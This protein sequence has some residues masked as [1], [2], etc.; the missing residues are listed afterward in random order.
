[1]TTCVSREVMGNLEKGKQFARD[2]LKVKTDKKAYM[3]KECGQ[4]A[5]EAAD[6]LCRRGK[7]TFFPQDIKIHQINTTCEVCGDRS[8]EAYI[9]DGKTVCRICKREVRK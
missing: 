7:V 2:S 8:G 9:I 3:K 6:Y 5:K 1:M 4:I